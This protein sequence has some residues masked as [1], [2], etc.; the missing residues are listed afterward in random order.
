MKIVCEHLVLHSMDFLGTYPFLQY[1]GLSWTCTCCV[2]QQKKDLLPSNLRFSRTS[3]LGNGEEKDD[4]D[5]SFLDSGVWLKIFSHLEAGALAKCF[6]VCKYWKTVASDNQLWHSLALK[7][8]CVGAGKNISLKYIYWYTNMMECDLWSN[9]LHRWMIAVNMYLKRVAKLEQFLNWLRR[10]LWAKQESWTVSPNSRNVSMESHKRV[11]NKNPVQWLAEYKAIAMGRRAVK[12]EVMNKHL[13]FEYFGSASLCDL[14]VHP[15]SKGYLARY[16]QDSSCKTVDSEI[17][18]PG[19]VRLPPKVLESS[20]A[21]VDSDILTMDR[22][23]HAYLV[24]FEICLL[25]RC[26][27]PAA[28]SQWARSLECVKKRT[29]ICTYF[30]IIKRDS[31]CAENRLVP[32]PWSTWTE[33]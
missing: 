1:D 4:V 9:L 23:A 17:V 32:C 24:V 26:L 25:L 20:I 31:V 15:Q 5:W 7:H 14:T 13:K 8:W 16:T 30:S 10:P 2:V 28:V 3:C 29:V 33:E 27:W 18:L 21:Q 12:A 22:C 6:S 11:S 19:R